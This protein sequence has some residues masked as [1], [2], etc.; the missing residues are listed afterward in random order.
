MHHKALVLVIIGLLVGLMGYIYLLT[1][2]RTNVVSVSPGALGL[3]NSIVRV[4]IRIENPNPVGVSMERMEFNLYYDNDG[5]LVYI[6]HGEKENIFLAPESNTTIIV[7]LIVSNKG[8]IKTIA[9][10][11]ME[12]NAEFIVKGKVYIGIGPIA[13]GIPFEETIKYK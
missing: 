7:P 13:I 12:R 5:T 6:G 1:R 3:H 10:I 9:K 8:L 11:I 2:L 4:K